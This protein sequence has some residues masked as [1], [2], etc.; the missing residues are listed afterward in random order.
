[1]IFDPILYRIQFVNNSKNYQLYVRELSNSSLFGFIEIGDFVFTTSSA[2]LVDPAVEKLKN[3]FTNVTRSYIPLQTIT[4]IDI[5]KDHT[6][7]IS[8]NNVIFFPFSPIKKT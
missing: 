5:V 3:E 2:L 7:P 4:R 8:N 1:M 6:Q